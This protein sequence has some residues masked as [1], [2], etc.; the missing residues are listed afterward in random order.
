M[1][2][3]PKTSGLLKRRDRLE[4]RVTVDQK[5]LIARAANLRGTS[6][7]DFVVESAQRAAKETIQDFEML[8]LR[9]EAREVFVNAILNP[10]PPNKAA[11]MAAARYKEDMG[12]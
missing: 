8:R 9:D 1:P 2:H 5:R 11:R 3:A 7:T 12:S 6:V 10:P 4:A